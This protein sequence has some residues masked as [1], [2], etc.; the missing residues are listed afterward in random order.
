MKCPPDM[1]KILLFS[2]CA[3]G[4]LIGILALNGEHFREVSNIGDFKIGEPA[5]YRPGERISHSYGIVPPSK[6]YVYAWEPGLSS[7]CVYEECGSGGEMVATLR[8][9]LWGV[10]LSDTPR[11]WYHFPSSL[12]SLIIIA[13]TD[14][15]IVGIYPNARLSDLEK[16]LKKH[17]DL[18]DFG[19][20]KGIRE[21]GG[22]RVGAPLPFKQTHMFEGVE[23]VPQQKPEFYVYVVHETIN[24]ERYCPYYE[25]GA[26]IDAVY[27]RP[28]SKVL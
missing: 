17:P 4:M 19:M 2:A 27:I 13:D 15:I 6:F 21:L 1:R 8:G 25:C 5:P 11:E 14:S 26:Y 12:K 28:L 16:I 20:M 24:S 18:A 10:D 7:Q 23:G 9:W 22:L 3:V